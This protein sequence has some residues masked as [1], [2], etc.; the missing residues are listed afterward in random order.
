MGKILFH[1]NSMGK[2]GAEH[3]ISILSRCFA[4]DGYDVV[5]TTLWQAD[6]EYALD[7]RVRRVNVGL[8]Q[9]EET[10][11]RLAKAA[12]RAFRYR[13]CIA[14]E[15]PDIVIS[16]CSKANFRS[17]YSMTGMRIPLLVSVRNDPQK[18]YAPYPAKCR[19][20]SRKA[21]GCVFQTPDAQRFFDER[22]Q[23]KSRVIWNP[24][25]EK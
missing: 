2:G 6:S 9:S 25:E 21:A 7:G 4:Q 24:L 16:F 15:K 10:R 1:V 20:M 13:Q 18:D 5:V 8:T 12:I 23:R 19:Y 17:A 22:L 14:R 3:V 11:G